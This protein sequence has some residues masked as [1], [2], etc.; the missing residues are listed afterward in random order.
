M[1]DYLSPKVQKALRLAELC[2]VSTALIT[3]KGEPLYGDKA[4]RHTFQ[5]L[6]YLHAFRIP[7]IEIQTSGYGLDND[8]LSRLAAKGVTTVA[9]S[10]VSDSLSKN[11]EIYGDD[12]E[13]PF[14]IARRI[15]DCGMMVRLCCSMCGGYVESPESVS[16]LIQSCACSGIEQLSFVPVRTIEAAENVGVREWVHKHE[17]NSK[18]MEFLYDKIRRRGEK[19]MTLMHGGEVYD[20]DGVSVCIRH[21]LTNDADSDAL[22]QVIVYPNGETRYSW[23]SRAARLIRGE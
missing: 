15:H 8:T 6:D 13:D 17:I 22:R 16:H 2:G 21:C 23:T 12:Y 4:Y 7:F 11:R 3:G 1:P 14:E 18:T 9:I 5:Y 10:C 19:L 20:V